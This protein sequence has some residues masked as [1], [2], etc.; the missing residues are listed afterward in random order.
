MPSKNIQQ[1]NDKCDTKSCAEKHLQF[2]DCD[3]FSQFVRISECR[4]KQQSKMSAL[5]CQVHFS[6][7]KMPIQKQIFYFRI[8]VSQLV[9]AIWT[10]STTFLVVDQCALV[11]FFFSSLSLFLPY[12]IL[13]SSSYWELVPSSSVCLFATPHLQLRTVLHCSQQQNRRRSSL[14]L[15]SSY[16]KI[17]PPPHRTTTLY[18]FFWFFFSL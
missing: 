16:S 10:R 12:A 1:K 18:Q 4:Q 9:V 5:F 6:R 14:T 11:S 3:I 13:A 7:F 8:E 2:E 15:S 17:P